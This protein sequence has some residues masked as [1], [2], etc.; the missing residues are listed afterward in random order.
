[1]MAFAKSVGYVTDY[2]LIQWYEMFI[3]VMLY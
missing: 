1:M 3:W 2:V